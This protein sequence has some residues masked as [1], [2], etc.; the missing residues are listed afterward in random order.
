[1]LVKMET[2]AA[3]GG[4]TLSSCVS[5]TTTYTLTVPSGVTNGILVVGQYNRGM[6]SIPQYVI[7][8][9]TATKIGNYGVAGLTGDCGE[10][11]SVENLS[12]TITID[13]STQS[14]PAP[15]MLLIY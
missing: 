13:S 3:A 12:S 5:V 1:M 7:S 15:N 8:G 2:Q 11:Y 4:G 9:C 6:S 14:S 10:V